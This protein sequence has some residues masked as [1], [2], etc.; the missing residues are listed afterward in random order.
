VPAH[1]QGGT[2]DPAENGLFISS[3]VADW[4]LE[5]TDGTIWQTEEEDEERHEQDGHVWLTESVS[6]ELQNGC[7]LAF[8]LVRVYQ[9]RSLQLPSDF[10]FSALRDDA[11]VAPLRWVNWSLLEPL[12][13]ELTGVELKAE[14]KAMIVAGE[15]E[16]LEKLLEQ[17]HELIF[18]P[19]TS[20][21]KQVEAEV[22]ADGGA[23]TAVVAEDKEIVLDTLKQL[24]GMYGMLMASFL[25]MF[26]QQSCAATSDNPNAHTCKIDDNLSH[27][28]TLA[29]L[30]LNALCLL[31]FVLGEV[32]YWKRERFM[33]FH[34]VMDADAPETALEEELQDY[35]IY[36]QRFQSLN[37]QAYLLTEVLAGALVLNCESSRVGSDAIPNRALQL[38]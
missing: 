24:G 26:V 35:P 1:S 25:L 3:G 19:R 20:T 8:V 10:E 22:K 38:R 33:I 11:H 34:F 17:I 30:V 7:T 18:D 16:P 27:P 4:L 14:E 28:L 15:R 2:D 9:D 37:K 12:V 5:R 32:V 6:D 29:T 36:R 21:G 13:L 31:I 23:A